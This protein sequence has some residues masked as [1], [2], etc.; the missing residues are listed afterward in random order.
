MIKT[1]LTSTVELG[2]QWERQLLILPSSSPASDTEL[3]FSVALD[4]VEALASLDTLGLV[5]TVV[6][7]PLL[8][9]C[10]AFS[11]FVLSSFTCQY[12]AQMYNVI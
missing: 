8:E 2:A 11:S 7:F 3:V 4:P 10:S 6:R 9:N 1:A 12:T 5:A